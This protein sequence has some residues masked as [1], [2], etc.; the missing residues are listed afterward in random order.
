MLLSV[1]YF[2][3][4]NLSQY[5]YKSIFSGA[6]RIFWCYTELVSSRRNTCFFFPLLYANDSRFEKSLESAVVCTL[7]RY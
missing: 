2:I 4:R 6:L 3:K 7:G 5:I 1:L